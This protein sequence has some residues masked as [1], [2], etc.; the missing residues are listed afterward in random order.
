[1]HADSKWE[2]GHKRHDEQGSRDKEVA[3]GTSNRRGGNY[4]GGGGCDFKGSKKMLQKVGEG[5]K[6]W[7]LFKTTGQ[8]SAY[9]E[10]RSCYKRGRSVLRKTEGG[11]QALKN[12]GIT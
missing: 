12:Q 9:E 2:Q 8:E 4:A 1:L 5:V 10:V 11:E 3:L 7:G 6:A